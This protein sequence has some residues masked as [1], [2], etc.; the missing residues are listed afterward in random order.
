[1]NLRVG[2]STR[3]RLGRPDART[4]LCSS[5]PALLDPG[6]HPR[7]A[8]GCR[9]AAGRASATSTATSAGASTCPPAPPPSPTT[10]RWRSRPSPRRLPQEARRAATAVRGAPLR[11]ACT[12]LLAKPAGC[13][14]GHV[15]RFAPGSCSA[16]RPADPV[17]GPRADP[18]DWIHEARPST[19]LPSVVAHHRRRGARADGGGMCRDFRPPRHLVLP[20]AR[21]SP[22]PATCSGYMP[23]IGIP[24]PPIPTMDFHAWFRGVAGG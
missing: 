10:R 12:W 16:T 13:E 8:V 11:V 19:G 3:L 24:R 4:P 22:G 7:R 21:P 15:R 14:S 23:D 17:R 18:G 9:A 5:R 6:H 20:R 1:M 2:V